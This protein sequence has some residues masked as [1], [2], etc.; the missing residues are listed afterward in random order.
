MKTN[1][2][3]DL[4]LK[5]IVEKYKEPGDIEVKNNETEL[6]KELNCKDTNLKKLIIF[7]G[8]NNT[9]PVVLDILSS[10]FKPNSNILLSNSST[11]QKGNCFI[12]G[13]FNK[14]FSDIINF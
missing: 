14:A 10:I 9:S 8:I 2:F 5:I 12:I 11:L 6:Y 4:L 3:D 7:Q 13:I 1:S